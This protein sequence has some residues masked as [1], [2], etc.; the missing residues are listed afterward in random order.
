M[1]Y[2]LGSRISVLKK[3]L[4]LFIFIYFFM[5]QDLNFRILRNKLIRRTIYFI[6]INY[7]ITYFSLSIS[8]ILVIITNISTTKSY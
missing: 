7:E 4:F 2:F 5:Y 6:Y 3:N 1:I 8:Q